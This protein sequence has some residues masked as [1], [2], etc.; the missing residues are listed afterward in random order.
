METVDEQNLNQY[1][2]E[3]NE[4]DM[5]NGAPPQGQEMDEMDDEEHE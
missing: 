2:G 4:E 1:Y 5:N 3:E